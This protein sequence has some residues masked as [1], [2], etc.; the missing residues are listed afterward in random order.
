MANIGDVTESNKVPIFPEAL[1]IKLHGEKKTVLCIITAT[2]KR[3]NP[4]TFQFRTS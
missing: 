1:W 3:T 2:T 4:G